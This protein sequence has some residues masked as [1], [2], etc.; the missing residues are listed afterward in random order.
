VG[1]DTTLV[2]HRHV[3]IELRLM[4]DTASWGMGLP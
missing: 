1:P 3:R 2:R 4:S